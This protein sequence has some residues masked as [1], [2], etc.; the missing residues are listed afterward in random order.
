MRSESGYGS[1]RSRTAF[2]T[3]KIAVLTAMPRVSA[4]TAAKAKAGLCTNMRRACLTSRT[5][6][7]IMS[8]P[9]GFGHRPGRNG[10][11][12]SLELDH[13]I[14]AAR[15]EEAGPTARAAIGAAPRFATDYL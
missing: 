12:L 10:L 6:V 1:G 7:S 4:A 8:D 9:R 13:P 5:V 11:P 14:R 15:H 3:E 2:T